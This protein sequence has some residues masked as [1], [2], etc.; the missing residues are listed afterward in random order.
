MKI[1]TLVLSLITLTACSD[2]KTAQSGS[3]VSGNKV[4]V[5]RSYDFAQLQR[6]GQLFQQH[7]AACHGKE[8]EGAANWQQRDADG[9]FPAP[10]LNGTAHAW[11]HPKLILIDTIK[12]GTKRIGG[13]MPAWEDKLSDKDIEDIIAWFQA[14]WPDQLYAA[15]Y[16][17]NQEALKQSQPSDN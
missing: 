13:N 11:H 2:D 16:R 3:A 8:A 7:C 5:Q 17:R 12:K 6:G 10:P 15:W 4:E 1:L 9:K 14:K